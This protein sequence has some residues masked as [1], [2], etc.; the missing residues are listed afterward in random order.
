MKY[1]WNE[2][3]FS[4]SVPTRHVERREMLISNNSLW[5]LQ[6]ATHLS[7]ILMPYDNRWAQENDEYDAFTVMNLNNGCIFVL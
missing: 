1:Y 6:Y 7:A 3:S 4:L 2:L 5:V